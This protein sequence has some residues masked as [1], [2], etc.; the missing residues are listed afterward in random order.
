[1]LLTGFCLGCIATVFL[2]VLRDFRHLLIGKLFLA[3]LIAASAYLLHAYIPPDWQWLTSDLMTTLPALFWAI[4]LLGF[5]SKHLINGPMLVVALYSFLAPALTRP[6]GDEFN[7]TDILQ[8]FAWEFAY[9]CEY[10]LICHGVYAVLSGWREDL[11]AER[12]KL[13]AYVLCILGA[14]SLCVTLSMNFGLDSQLP[15]VVVSVCCVF[16]SQLM[17]LTRRDSLIRRVERAI[18][19]GRENEVGLPAA[20]TSPKGADLD[21]SEALQEASSDDLPEALSEALCDLMAAG[22]YRSEKLT[23]KSLAKELN[24]P[25]HRLRHLINRRFKYKS[26]R[27]YINQLRVEEASQRLVIEHERPIQNI[28]LDV[29][30]RTM[31]SFNRAFKDIQACTPSE[32]RARRLSELHEEGHRSS[33]AG[34]TANNQVL[35]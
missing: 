8:I 6:F 3:L 19:H 17:L 35:S 4:C 13:R 16:C 32:F 14:T 22:Y 2:S 11:L 34:E 15:L 7:Q 31:S 21:V 24:V 28:A 1:M 30:Y 33:Y 9:V 12:R 23:L 25:E 20:F 5:G 29:G 27:D 10:I 18:D 26:F